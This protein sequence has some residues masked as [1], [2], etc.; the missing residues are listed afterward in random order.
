MVHIRNNHWITIGSLP[1]EEVAENVFIICDSQRNQ[2]S[3]YEKDLILAI[4]NYLGRVFPRFDTL[5]LRFHSM[6]K[7]PNGN[8]C[9][10]AIECLKL[11]VFFKK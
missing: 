2:D 6:D 9:G 10:Y 8:D 11:Q 4:A 1:D 3:V 5:Q 7:Q